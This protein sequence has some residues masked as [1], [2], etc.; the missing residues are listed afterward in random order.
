MSDLS[1]DDYYKILGVTKTADEKEL[2][3]AYR[4]LAL[5]WH[6]DKNQDNKEK[7][8]DNFK[9]VSEAYE[10][11]S[12]KEKRNLYDQ[13]GK[14]GLMGSSNGM[15]G[16]GGGMPGNMNFSGFQFTNP[17]DLFSQIFGDDDPFSFM[18]S[19]NNFMRGGNRTFRFV[20][21]DNNS[22]FSFMSGDNDNP[23]SFINNGNMSSNR[24][25][26]NRASNRLDKGCKVIIEGLVS[27]N[28]LNGLI[29]LVLD[30]NKIKDRYMVKIEGT[31]MLWLKRANII[32]MVKKIKITGIKSSPELNNKT[33][34]IIGWEKA[35]ERFIIKLFIGKTILVKRENIIWPKNTLVH[36][37]KLVG[38]K[39]YNGKWGKVLN[40]DGVRYNVNLDSSDTLRLKPDNISIVCH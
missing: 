10:V 16:F 34:D 6:P 23:F 36:I 28:E 20:S 26:N 11:L 9:K 31:I 7:A 1:S 19:G 40:Y 12:N 29:G 33:G 37:D 17:N 18:S 25:P 21:S 30:Y 22:P 14:Q 27:R 13:F 15:G 2:K 35:S 8:E 32:E 39:K 4:K 5:K 38:A 24:S 3:K